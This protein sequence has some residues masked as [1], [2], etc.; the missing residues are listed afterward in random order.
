MRQRAIYR[1]RM[2]VSFYKKIMLYGVTKRGFLRIK[3]GIL[4]SAQ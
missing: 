2:R 4:F 1:Y 3:E